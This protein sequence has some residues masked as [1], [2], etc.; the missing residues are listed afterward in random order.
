MSNGNNFFQYI[1]TNPMVA[2]GMVT[3]IIIA[4]VILIKKNDSKINS[5]GVPVIIF[6]GLIAVATVINVVIILQYNALPMPKF[7]ITN[8]LSTM[9]IVTLFTG[10]IVLILKKKVPVVTILVVLIALTIIIHSAIIMQLNH[11][12]MPKELETNEID[13]LEKELVE[14]YAEVRELEVRDQGGSQLSITVFLTGNISEEVSTQILDKIR[15]M[16]IGHEFEDDI[17]EY[18][19]GEFE[20]L[21]KGKD[22]LLYSFY[23]TRESGSASIDLLEWDGYNFLNDEGFRVNFK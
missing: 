12:F 18:S 17:H 9:I 8:P 11:I 13:R 23:G 15:K 3:L 5:I 4:I 19:W 22:D 16:L 21:Y 7:A 20:V 10:A 6:L 2:I 1:M 14:D